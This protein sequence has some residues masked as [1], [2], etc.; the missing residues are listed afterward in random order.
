MTPVSCR[1]DARDHGG[2]GIRTKSDAVRTPLEAGPR[3]RAPRKIADQ[4]A[5]ICVDQLEPVR[6]LPKQRITF[7]TH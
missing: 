2:T 3:S 6:T 5:R 4:A 7:G 1:R